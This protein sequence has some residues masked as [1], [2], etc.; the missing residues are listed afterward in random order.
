MTWKTKIPIEV[1]KAWPEDDCPILSYI[2][3]IQE[4]VLHFFVGSVIFPKTCYPYSN[5]VSFHVAILD[6]VVVFSL[7]YASSTITYLH[8]YNAI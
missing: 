6:I 3:P 8:S 4:I 5:F 1:C 7:S 2:L